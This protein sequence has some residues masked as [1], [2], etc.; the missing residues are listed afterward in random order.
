ML[1]VKMALYYMRNL[2]TLQSANFAISWVLEPTDPLQISRNKCCQPV[3]HNIIVDCQ[4]SL[5]YQ[6]QHD[7]Y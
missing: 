4:I 7:A 5:Q 3:V 6:S 1:H 2:N